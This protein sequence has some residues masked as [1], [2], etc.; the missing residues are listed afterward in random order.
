MFVV[1]GKCFFLILFVN[2]LS[3][4]NMAH[5]NLRLE[6]NVNKKCASKCAHECILNCFSQNFILSCMPFYFS[7]S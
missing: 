6:R 7:I 4:K 5:T 3:I 2:S 1:S